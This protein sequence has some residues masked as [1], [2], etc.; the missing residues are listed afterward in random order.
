MDSRLDLVAKAVVR[1]A[2]AVVVYWPDSRDGLRSPEHEAAA[3]GLV[4]TN[5]PD[6]DL[7]LV[8]ELAAARARSA[9]PPAPLA[10]ATRTQPAAA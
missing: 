3:R 8:R 1:A 4:W 2:A 6:L 7:T 10:P 9:W 5:D